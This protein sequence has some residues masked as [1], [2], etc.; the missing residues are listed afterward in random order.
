MP[1]VVSWLLSGFAWLFRSQLGQ[2]I[3]AA[4]AWLGISFAVSEFAVEPLLDAL[5]MHVQDISGAGPYAAAAL[6]WFGVLKFDIACT[7][8]ASAVAIKYA[9]GAAGSALRLV[10]RG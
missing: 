9:T 6:A 7:M 10:K 3:V 8:I 4:M 2:F 1:V 5:Q